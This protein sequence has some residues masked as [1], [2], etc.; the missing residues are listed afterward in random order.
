MKETILQYFTNMIAQEEVPSEDFY[1]NRKLFKNTKDDFPVP[2][3]EA[4]TYY[5]E[6]V[7]YADWGSASLYQM[8]MEGIEDDVYA[9]HTTTDG[10]D[11]WLEIYDG[12]GEN[13]GY[14]RFYLTK[15]VFKDIEI[16]KQVMEGGLPEELTGD[17]A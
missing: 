6:N 14:G 17:L 12:E 5:L 9:I 11:G 15:I 10:D 3:Q 7:E 13:I 1:I 8:E 16:R 4:Y 2:V